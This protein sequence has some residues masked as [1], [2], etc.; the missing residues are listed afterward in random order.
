[1]HS[2]QLIKHIELKLMELKLPYTILKN[3]NLLLIVSKIIYQELK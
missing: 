3:Q 1:M 2:L